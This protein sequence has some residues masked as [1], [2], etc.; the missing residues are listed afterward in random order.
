MKPNDLFQIKAEGTSLIDNLYIQNWPAHCFTISSNGLVM[1]NLIL[2]NTA[3]N[4]P[5]NRS[6]GLAAAH[7]SDGFD[8]SSSTNMV[9]LNTIV[10]NQDDCVAITSGNNITASGMYCDGSHGLSIGSIGGKSNNNVTN[11]LFENSQVLN[12]QNGVRIKANYNTT[13]FVSDITYRNVHI[14]NASIY[15]LDIQ[16][17]Y[18]NGGPTG[19]PTN[20][21]IIRNILFQ[22]VTGTA[23]AD[24]TNYYIL[25]GEGACSNFTFENV[26]ITGGTN[27][28]CNVHGVGSPC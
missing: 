27:D 12:S 24:A 17:D 13:G 6:N 19:T 16:E 20:G 4:A 11:I 18:L 7:N 21:V 14:V 1:E 5:N 28:S 8:I 10:L 2:N 9:L 25:C 3:G 15:G 23:N 22:N 26:S